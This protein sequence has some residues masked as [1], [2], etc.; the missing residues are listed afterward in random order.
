M[1]RMRSKSIGTFNRQNTLHT[2]STYPRG[3]N[4]GRFNYTISNFK[5]IFCICPLNTILT[6]PPQK[7]KK[8]N[9]EQ[10]ISEIQTLKFHNSLQIW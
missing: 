4:F 1:Y 7:K 5:K 6:P 2:L 9:K 8:K 3:Q 10:K